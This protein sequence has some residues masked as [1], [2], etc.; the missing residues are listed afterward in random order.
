[1][2]G[3]GQIFIDIKSSSSFYT[4]GDLVEEAYSNQI[5]V[6]QYR[7]GFH[8]PIWKNIEVG[9]DAIY[10]IDDI[11]T[12]GGE[13]KF[14]KKK[15]FRPR[16]IPDHEVY[17]TCVAFAAGICQQSLDGEWKKAMID[18]HVDAIDKKRWFFMVFAVIQPSYHLVANKSILDGRVREITE[19]E[20][21]MRKLEA[22]Y[23]IGG[24]D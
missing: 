16:W 14:L 20:D 9:D 12:C 6:F 10:A 18:K 11:T 22:V 4:L 2:D 5:A 21:E 15:V 7:I 3:K 8:L 13:I 24:V 1:M 19:A 23:S 17:K